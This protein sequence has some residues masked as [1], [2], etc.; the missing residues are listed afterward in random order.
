MCYFKHSPIK[1]H[2]C[3][4]AIYQFCKNIFLFCFLHQVEQY[5]L[6]KLF[7]WRN[8]NLKSQNGRVDAWTIHSSQ[9]CIRKWVFSIK[10]PKSFQK[11]LLLYIILFE[12]IVYTKIIIYCIIKHDWTFSSFVAF[13]PSSS[14]TRL[15]ISLKVLAIMPWFTFTCFF[16]VITP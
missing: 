14:H 1:T 13:P 16:K 2:S 12:K 5:F 15:F 8:H 11:F 10:S 4:I 6:Q 3:I 7:S 9:N